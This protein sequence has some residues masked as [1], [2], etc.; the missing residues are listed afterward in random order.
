LSQRG[1]NW[2][3][4]DKIAPLAKKNLFK[5][6]RFAVMRYLDVPAEF[7]TEVLDRRI[8]IAVRVSRWVSRP[9]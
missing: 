8:F 7:V 4:N 9:I 6:H 2:D 3:K 5:F 1:T